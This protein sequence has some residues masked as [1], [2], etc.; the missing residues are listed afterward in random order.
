[1]H[2]HSCLNST[3]KPPHLS[4]SGLFGKPTLLNNVE[5]YANISEIIKNGGEWFASIG[6][7]D[8]SGTKVFALTGQIKHTGLV[9]V[10]M[11]TTI[12]ELIY[13]IGGGLVDNKE[14]KAIQTGGPSGGCIPKQFIDMPI[15]SM[16]HSSR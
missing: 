5:T 1:L 9:E 8:S 10:P 11:G 6:T 13:D 14:Y 4:E 2:L 15:E 12:R 16:V 7:E 3:Q